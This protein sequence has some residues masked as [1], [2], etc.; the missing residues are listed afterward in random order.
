M[1]ADQAGVDAGEADRFN[2]EFP[3]NREDARVD[4]A[5]EHHR[6]HVDRLLIGDA[7]PMDHPRLE[8]Q[9]RL[10]VIELRTAAVHQHGLDAHLV[11]DGDLFDQRTRGGLVAEHR[12]ARLDDEHLVLVHA[13]VRRG[14]LE[15]AHGGRRIRAVHYHRKILRNVFAGC[16]HA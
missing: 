6:R 2:V 14:A 1:R 9:G 12:A 16:R 11:Q 8:P 10:H 5:V 7:P 15:G 4:E 13:D 3:A